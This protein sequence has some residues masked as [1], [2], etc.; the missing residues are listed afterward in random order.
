[1]TTARGAAKQRR[2]LG[3]S[4]LFPRAGV[5]GNGYGG[6]GAYTWAGS[7]VPSSFP[8]CRESVPKPSCFQWQRWCP[9]RAGIRAE[10]KQAQNVERQ[11]REL[12]GAAMH[13][14]ALGNTLE[15]QRLLR[16]AC[17]VHSNAAGRRLERLLPL[18][19]DMPRCTR[20][21]A[22]GH[23]RT[24]GVQ[25]ARQQREPFPYNLL[26]DMPYLSMD[27]RSQRDGVCR[28]HAYL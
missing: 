23:F 13:L 3:H 17:A 10:L 12:A 1:M 19:A 18:A 22:V 14:L 2:S 9:R 6:T 27:L 7:V 5:A 26:R 25:R 15:A 11:G 20:W 16:R 24:N 8:S 28:G 4:W 21:S